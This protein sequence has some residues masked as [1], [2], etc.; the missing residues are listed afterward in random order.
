MDNYFVI[1]GHELVDKFLDTQ[2]DPPDSRVEEALHSFI[3][4]LFNK[5]SYI[6]YRYEET[7]FKAHEDKIKE[8]EEEL[9]EAREGFIKGYDI[10]V[11][12]KTLKASSEW[13][14]TQ[15]NKW[16]GKTG[17]L[18]AE[19]RPVDHPSDPPASAN[20]SKVSEK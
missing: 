13:Q 10:L 20:S 1:L 8:L 2:S 17:L 19:Q 15:L 9:R 6:V 5:E 4:F 3:T 11:F 18:K 7:S 14:L 12:L 16:I